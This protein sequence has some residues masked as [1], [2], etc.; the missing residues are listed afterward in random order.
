MYKSES[1]IHNA[2]FLDTNFILSIQKYNESFFIKKL[3]LIY[4]IFRKV[5]RKIELICQSVYITK[6][7]WNILWM[8]KLYY[9]YPG[10]F[11][12]IIK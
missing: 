1:K 9:V 10:V 4:E 11:I 2:T 5:K 6:D 7:N 3:K 12:Y 8:Y